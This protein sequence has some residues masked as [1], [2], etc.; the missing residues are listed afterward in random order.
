MIHII[1]FEGS[2][3]SGV[4]EMGCV[5]I[6]GSRITQVTGRFF[7]PKRTP[8]EEEVAIHGIRPSDYADKPLFSE[9]YSDLIALRKSGPFGAHHAPVENGFLTRQWPAIEGVPDFSEKTQTVFDW[10][11]WIDTLV[12]VK[13]AYPQFSENGL[14]PCI[15]ALGLET[16]LSEIAE[17]QIPLPRQRFHAAPYD[18]LAS[19]LLV[20][21]LSRFE[22]FNNWSI[23]DWVRASKP[24]NSSSQLNL[25]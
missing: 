1:D 6:D 8:R 9:A 4:V 16:E 21:E 14:E 7:S 12:L 15:K 13:K 5:T 24:G 3:T 20:L 19:A 17:A 18:A 2:A 11:P 22:P 23:R 10:G 25:W